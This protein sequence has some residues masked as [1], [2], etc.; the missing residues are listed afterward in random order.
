MILSYTRPCTKRI[1]RYKYSFFF[2]FSCR[3]QTQCITNGYVRTSAGRTRVC[4]FFVHIYIYSY[5]SCLYII[6]YVSLYTSTISQEKK[7]L[8]LGFE[9]KGPYSVRH[10]CYHGAA[11]GSG[12]RRECFVVPPTRCRRTRPPSMYTVFLLEL[13]TSS[14]RILAAPIS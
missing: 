13:Y 6:V 4:F 14:G 7:D 9:K 11:A 5:T 8:T 2:L 1:V 10:S 12:N 3:K